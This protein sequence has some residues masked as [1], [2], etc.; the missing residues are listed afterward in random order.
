[1]TDA[2][3]LRRLQAGEPEALEDLMVQYSRYVYT[4]I[5]NI[6]GSAGRPPDVEELVSDTF[7]SIWHHAGTIRAGKL[8][9]YLGTTARNKAKSFLRGRKELP[10]DLDCLELAD[11]CGAPEEAVLQEELDRQVKRAIQK[12]RP[13]DREIFLRYYYYFQPTEQIAVQMSI[14]P[15]T[16]RSRLSRGRK[17]L[18]NILSKEGFL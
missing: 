11:P 8:K 16:V 4:V 14:P 18:K 3:L 5:A 15:G 2:P 17:I 1:M 10:M 7:L 6:L 12:M 9:A 13:K